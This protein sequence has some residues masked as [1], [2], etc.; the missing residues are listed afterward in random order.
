V[1][2]YIG[3]WVKILM[4]GRGCVGDGICGTDCSSIQPLQ[5]VKNHASH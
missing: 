4:D 5:K 2:I 3:C 1:E